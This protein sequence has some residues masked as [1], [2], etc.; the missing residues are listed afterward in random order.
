MFGNRLLE[1]P[2]QDHLE[3]F[4]ALAM[5]PG[6]LPQRRLGGVSQCGKQPKRQPRLEVP[7]AVLRPAYPVTVDQKGADAGA[8]A[9]PPQLTHRTLQTVGGKPPIDRGDQ[10]VVSD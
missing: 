3:Q 4:D 5:A 10:S 8:R 2:P 6:D 9:R 7:K 1:L